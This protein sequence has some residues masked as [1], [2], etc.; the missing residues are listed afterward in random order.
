MRIDILRHVSAGKRARLTASKRSTSIY[1]FGFVTAHTFLP[2]KR[3][4]KDGERTNL[5]LRK[6]NGPR[7][8]QLTRNER[9][10]CTY[11]KT[12]AFIVHHVPISRRSFCPSLSCL[13]PSPL[14]HP[15]RA[16][17]SGQFEKRPASIALYMVHSRRPEG[18]TE[19]IG[20][21][22]KGRLEAH[23]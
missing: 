10:N 6:N 17:D 22:M 9:K 18:G 1:A 7:S 12:M 3:N 13:R 11:L 23:I 19:A 14:P 4:A 8:Q 20:D 15:S 16:A 21:E 5:N 2:V